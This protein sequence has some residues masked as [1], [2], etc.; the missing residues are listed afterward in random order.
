MDV[1]GRRRH[2]QRRRAADVDLGVVPGRQPG[3][4]PRSGSSSNDDACGTSTATPLEPPA[5][6]R[7]PLGTSV[8]PAAGPTYLLVG[9]AVGCREPA[10]GRRVSTPRSRPDCSRPTCSPRRSTTGRRRCCSATRTCST[11]GTAPTTR[12]ADSPNRLLGRPAVSRRITRARGDPPGDSPTPFIR[13]A[14]DELRRSGA[15]GGV[16][17]ADR[18]APGAGAESTHPRPRFIDRRRRTPGERDRS[19]GRPDGSRVGAAQMRR[20]T[21]AATKG[22]DR[23]REDHRVDLQAS[24]Q[25]LSHRD[26]AREA[27]ELEEVVRRADVA[28]TGADVAER[29][30]RPPRT[31]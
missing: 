22:H 20:S 8:G 13:L 17:R 12:S 15:I 29:R 11:S 21:M 16:G 31:T 6:G 9:D 27:R 23:Q 10:V 24:E 7:I 30:R 1:P 18:T 4:P 25:H 28:E 19:T 5:S 26:P 2:R 3:P 14:T